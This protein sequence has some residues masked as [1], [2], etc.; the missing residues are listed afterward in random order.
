MNSLIRTLP[1]VIVVCHYVN[2]FNYTYE[3][4]HEKTCLMSNANNKGAG[5]PE[6]LRSLINTFV[7]RCLDSIIPLLSIAKISSLHLASVAEQA[8]LCL[9][10]SQTP[11]DRFSHDEAHIYFQWTTY[12]NTLQYGCSWKLLQTQVRTWNFIFILGA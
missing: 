3:P 5:Q 11:E 10:W 6:H 7:V 8:G 12:Q 2:F 1:V 9:T 4:G